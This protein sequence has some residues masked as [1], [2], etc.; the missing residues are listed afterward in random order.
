[1]F[2]VADIEWALNKEYRQSL[3]QIA[4]VM[5]NEAWSP[6]AYYS[7]FIKP[8]NKSFEGWGQ[9]CYTGGEPSDFLSAPTAYTV[10]QE[11]EEWA[12]KDAVLLFWHKALCDMYR[13][14]YAI[15]FKKE[16]PHK[17][18]AVAEY[19]TAFI[20]KKQS[21]NVNAYQLAKKEG[22]LIPASEHY[23]VN[24]ANVVLRLLR[25][26]K[27]KQEKFFQSP[28][29]KEAVRAEAQ[30]AKREGKL[31]DATLAIEASKT[32]N[33]F[34]VKPM[35]YR[36][37]LM[38]KLLHKKDCPYIPLG[39]PIRELSTI[40]SCVQRKFKP[41][42][43]IKEELLRARINRNIDI[44]NRSPYNY[45]Y[46]KGKTTFHKYT[47]RC[48]LRTNELILGTETYERLIFSGKIPCK[49]CNPSP[50]DVLKETSHKK[51]SKTKEIKKK[52]LQTHSK[53][54]RRAI[55]RHKQVNEEREKWLQEK[56]LTEQ[57]VQD[58]FTLTQPEF[59]FFAMKGCATF[60][61][62]HCSR[63][64]GGSAFKG[65]K[66]YAQAICARLKP[67]K[68]CKPTAKFDTK[69]SIPIGNRERKEESIDELVALCE[70][71]GYL[72]QMEETFFLIKT[73]VGEWELNTKTNPVQVKHN[74][75]VVG[76]GFHKQPRIFLSLHDAFDY[77][78]RHDKSLIKEMNFKNK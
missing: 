9:A 18:I 22:I 78:E 33:Q 44:I 64:V 21:A 31:Y 10:L 30:G 6:I 32:S 39:H 47:C 17:C 52:V 62:R 57:R 2:V 42:H 55:R 56:D 73:P 26:V 12:G 53:A 28:Q 7:S 16:S 61:L 69:V 1:M 27:I 38:D 58:I 48:V 77:I 41:C 67:C 4:G 49:V 68:I 14:M 76:G 50:S 13:K 46:I 19:V 3:T 59:S 74:N 37:D 51:L 34:I 65:F 72:Y 20:G 63:L 70:K 5:V 66:E 43:C 40:Q 35:R 60:H 54:E 45:I 8:Q 29:T 71:K 15:L 25:K 24:D 11:F 23:A 75:L 36:Y